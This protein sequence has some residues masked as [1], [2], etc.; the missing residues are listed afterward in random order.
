MGNKNTENLYG[1]T[2]SIR[3]EDPLEKEERIQV[4]RPCRQANAVRRTSFKLSASCR[5]SGAC[6]FSTGGLQDFSNGSRS[7]EVSVWR[8]KDSQEALTL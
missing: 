2:R 1:G 4:A 8:E 7:S 5:I 3:P 6:S